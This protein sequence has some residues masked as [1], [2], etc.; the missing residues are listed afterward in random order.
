MA[1]GTAT[2]TASVSVSG[3]SGLVRA[4]VVAV[5]TVSFGRLLDRFSRSTFAPPT[6][7]VKMFS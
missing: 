5:T 4:V 3:V 1:A 7:S 6:E 2:A